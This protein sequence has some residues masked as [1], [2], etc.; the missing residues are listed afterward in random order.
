ME[1][2]VREFIAHIDVLAERLT[3]ARRPQDRAEPEC[4]PPELK[5][6]AA[7]GRRNTLGMS[8]LAAILK[9]PL[10]TATHTVDK[11][12]AK[13]LVERKHVK[14]DRRI[15][16]VTF[17]KKGKRI[18]RFVLESQIA[19]GRSMLEALGSKER[20]ILLQQM[21]KLAQPPVAKRPKIN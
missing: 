9:V 16:Q 8:D 6:F 1:K 10:S 18:H 12:V 14:H 17:S 5:V 15:V 21:A 19:V 2:Q 3:P 7:L 4:S 11:L 20:G 13:D